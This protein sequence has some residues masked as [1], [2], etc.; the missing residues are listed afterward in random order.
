MKSNTPTK[1]KVFVII[2]KG[3]NKN[4]LK[5]LVCDNIIVDAL[6]EIVSLEGK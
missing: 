3:N 2:D 4:Y 5:Q 1:M 6:K